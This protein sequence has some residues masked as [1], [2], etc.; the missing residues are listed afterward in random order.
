M[1]TD[2]FRIGSDWLQLAVA[3][4]CGG[5]IALWTSLGRRDR[6]LML[7]QDAAAL[8][9]HTLEQRI[10]RLE[11]T[12]A[13]PAQCAAH[14]ARIVALEE[15]RRLGVTHEDMKHAHIRMDAFEGK[16]GHMTGLLEGIGTAV[17]RIHQH[18]LEYGPRAGE[19]P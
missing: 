15:A 17:N 6:A 2:W 5:V 19:R 16:I 8:D 10:A 1:D 18:L 13:T 9:V 14:V 3:G 12:G 4:A 7:R 11:A